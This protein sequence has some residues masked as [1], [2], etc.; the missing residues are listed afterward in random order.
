[1]SELGM[2]EKDLAAGFLTEPVRLSTTPPLWLRGAVLAAEC[3]Q[4]L[5]GYPSIPTGLCAS[6]AVLMASASL[7]YLASIDWHV[8]S[9]QRL[10]TAQT[11]SSS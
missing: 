1:M 4:R 6:L 10:Q 3:G 8:V 2:R 11:L 9:W 5:I 7:P